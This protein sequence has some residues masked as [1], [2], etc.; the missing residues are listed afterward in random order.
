MGLNINHGRI[1]VIEMHLPDSTPNIFL[2]LLLTNDFCFINQRTH[3]Q[4]TD[5]TCKVLPEGWRYTELSTGCSES[6]LIGHSF[7]RRN[8]LRTSCATCREKRR[9]RLI[10][11][12]STRCR[13]ATFFSACSAALSQ[14]VPTVKCMSNQPVL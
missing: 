2:R 6:S 14:E 4:L 8:F 3:V 1:S 9:R 10:R 7:Y 12:L 5:F 13:A 11:L